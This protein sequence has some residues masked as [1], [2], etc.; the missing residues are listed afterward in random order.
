MNYRFVS[1]V[2]Y[3]TGKFAII[4]S[5]VAVPIL[6]VFRDIS[7][8]QMILGVNTELR[9]NAVILF[10][11]EFWVTRCKCCKR[12][13]SVTWWLIGSFLKTLLRV[14]GVRG[15]KTEIRIKFLGTSK[16]QAN[17]FAPFAI[18]NFWKTSA[19]ISGWGRSRRKSF[20]K[21]QMECMSKWPLKSAKSFSEINQQHK[22]WVE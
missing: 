5:S 16:I 3:R 10:W 6:S 21:Q 18:R 8:G 20:T 22:Q 7:V 19:V 15:P 11:S 14:S 13:L 4:I 12:Y 17:I 9:L 2:G 1:A